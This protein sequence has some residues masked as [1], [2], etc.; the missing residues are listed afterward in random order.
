D[1]GT[2]SAGTSTADTPTPP[3]GGVDTGTAQTTPPAGGADTGTAQT[4]PPAGGADT[5]TAQTTPPAGGDT[6]TQS[7]DAGAKPMDSNAFV[8]EQKD[9]QWLAT[10][11][12]GQAVYNEQDEKIG[13]INDLVLDEGG[14]IAAVV[15]GV[16]G[17]LG[18][19]EKDVAITYDAVNVQKDENN[20]IKLVVAGSKEALQDAP[21]FKDKDD[22]EAEQNANSPAAMS[23]GGMGGASPNPAA[24]ASSGSP[25]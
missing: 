24:P 9:E 2:P 4:T 14:G 22:M 19:G 3:A 20:D 21:E 6:A 12:V 23:G 11:Y 15:I 16:G 10:D 13:S 18:I 5:G 25:Q 7:A 1:T 8:T 17:F